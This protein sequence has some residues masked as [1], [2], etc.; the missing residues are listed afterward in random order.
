[1]A[2]TVDGLYSAIIRLNDY[3]LRAHWNGEALVG[4]DSGVRWNL[5][6]G[7]FAKSYLHFLPWHDSYVFMQTQAY[8]IL[9]NWL[10]AKV[11]GDNQAREV[12]LACSDFLERSQQ[13][14]GHWIYPPL[15]SRVGK[16]ATVEGNLAAIS[17]LATYQHTQ[18]R[19]YLLSAEQWH[20][21][22][23]NVIGFQAENGT[24]AVNYWAN[25]SQARVP[26]NTTLTLWLLAELAAA[27]NDRQ[28]LAAGP[29][30]ISFLGQVQMA[31]GELPYAVPTGASRGRLH[32]LCYQYNA[33]EFLD[34]CHYYWSTGNA[35]I[36]P[37][38][39]KLAHFLASGITPEGG[40]RHNCHAERPTTV[41]YAAAVAAALGQAKAL[42]VGDFDSSADQAY[43]WVMARQVADGGMAYF[44]R[45][46]YGFLIDRRSY[47]R[48]LAMILYHM[49]LRLQA[50]MVQD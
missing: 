3:M 18:D 39:G 22:L 36:L 23:N 37:V 17:L 44:S 30:L 16:V 48:N 45:G 32:Y 42:G 20:S 8:W 24:M 19:K 41:Y 35:D 43:D 27:T 26:N 12:A 5:R 13:A 40:V 29:S 47:P 31:T 38:M 15:R 11:A 28:Y 7:R 50:K 34:L 49:L 2:K 6:L 4:P 25:D 21:Y 10:L 33:F 14:D 1:V 9:A 46:N